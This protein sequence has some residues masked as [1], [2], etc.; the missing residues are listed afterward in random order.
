MRPVGAPKKPRR[1]ILDQLAHQGIGVGERERLLIRD[2]GRK[3]DPALAGVET[4]QHEFEPLAVGAFGRID[5]A[6]VLEHEATRRLQNLRLPILLLLRL[7]QV[8]HRPAVLVGAS[9][10]ALIDRLAQPVRDAVAHRARPGQDI[11]FAVGYARPGYDDSPQP[12]GEAALAVQRDL[13]IVLIHH[14]LHVQPAREAERV[15][16][17][18]PILDRGVLELEVAEHVTGLKGKLLLRPNEMK[19]RVARARRQFQFRLRIGAVDLG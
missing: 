11:E 4:S 16:H 3:L 17:P 8:M 18:Q 1:R 19:V 2:A 10:H 9:H 5:A 14:R 7:H 13:V 12:V 6:H 15:L